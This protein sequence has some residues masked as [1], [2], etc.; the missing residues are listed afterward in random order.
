MCDS[1]DLAITLY[2][3]HK[4]NFERFH[5]SGFPLDLLDRMVEI[6]NVVALKLAILEPGFIFETFRRYGEKILVQCPWERWL[7]LLNAQ[8][9]QQW[10]GAGAYEAFQSPEKPYLVDYFNLLLKG[11]VDKAME[12]FWMLTPVRMMFEKQFMPTVHLGTYHWPQH[13]YYQWLTGGN[14]GFTRQPV[15]KMYKHEMEETK[16]AMRAIGLTL[17]EPEE[18]YYVG[19]CNYAK[20]K[21]QTS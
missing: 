11:E 19:R 7:P 14:G 4:Y 15:M 13:K 8:F 5:P 2:P 21:K 12:I 20:M 18:E 17:R 9:G 6:E 10:M 3:T 1:T 16:G